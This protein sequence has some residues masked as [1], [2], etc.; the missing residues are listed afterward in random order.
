MSPQRITPKVIVETEYF[1]SNNSIV[2]GS[3]GLAS[4]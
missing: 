1:G 4:D 2:V 3:E